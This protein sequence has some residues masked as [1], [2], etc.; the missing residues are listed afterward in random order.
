M[1]R[2]SG[3]FLTIIPVF[4]ALIIIFF[5]F[6]HFSR[7][8][9]I[10]LVMDNV[11]FKG[12][13]TMATGLSPAR[14]SRMAVYTNGLKL[15]FSSAETLKVITEDGIVRELTLDRLERTDTGVVLHFKYDISI[16][17][18]S[19]PQ[20]SDSYINITIPQTIPPIKELRI[21]AQAQDSYLLNKD[22]EG[23]ITLSDGTSTYFMNSSGILDFKSSILSISMDDRVSNRITMEDEAPGLGRSVREWLADSEK[24]IP[25]DRETLARYSDK[26]DSGW[27]S[28]F[29]KSTGNWTMP[30][31]A[32]SFKEKA[33]VQ[34]MAESYRRGEQTLTA[35]DLLKS[36]EKNISALSWYSSPFIGDIVNRT[37]P[38]LRSGYVSLLEGKT[39]LN[40]TANP[41]VSPYREILELK[42]LLTNS[43]SED[44]VPWIEE[45][46][47]PLIVWLEEGLYILHPDNPESSTLFTLEAA[48]LLKSAAIRTGDENLLSISSKIRATILSRADENGILPEKITFSRERASLGEGAIVPEDVYGLYQE[49]AFAPRFIDL[50][51][52]KDKETWLYTAARSSSVISN[53]QF[54][55]LKVQFPK[56][57]IHHLVLKGIEPFDRVFLHNIRWKSDPRFQRY[58]D[59]WVYDAVNKTLYVKIK[60]RVEEEMIRIQF[61]PAE[62]EDSS[63]K[64]NVDA[65]T[66][67][68]G[69]DSV[70]DLP[71]GTG[72]TS[73]ESLPGAETSV[74]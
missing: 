52:G 24:I 55:E 73:R 34:F 21:R 1:K 16:N 56:G 35:A 20:S 4:Y 62:E 45:N 25:S 69:I 39:S 33:L 71:S 18:S 74:E 11:S 61:N 32:P 40:L 36:A 8:E 60:H 12:T 48:E 15:S 49:T 54:L 2:K 31:G 47:Y 72:S 38:L 41:D 42:K 57:Q 10:S 66:L 22:N 17:I 28:R 29:D 19:K 13:K 6:L 50:S 5:L 44:P 46:I 3:S 65:E 64:T 63:P 27:K 53:D 43:E 14:I 51:N 7:Y 37:A 58:S 30:E 9:E 68:N 23:R 59:G 26:S 70:G 67:D